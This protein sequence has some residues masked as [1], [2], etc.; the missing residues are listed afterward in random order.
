MAVTQNTYTGD[1]ST[2]LFSFTFPYLETTD[3]KVSLNGTVTTA[4]TLANATTIEFNTAPANGAAIRIYRETDDS[5]LLA[6]FYPGSAIRSQDLNDNFTQTLYVS[7]ETSRNVA[8]AVA[9]QIPDG[10]ITTSKLVDGVITNA[11]V[12]SLGSP[13]V[14]FTQAGTG[15]TQRTVESKLQDVVSVKDFG[16]VGDGVAD[17]TAAFTVALSSENVV[18]VPVGVYRITSSLSFQNTDIVGEGWGAI[19]EGDIVSAADPL[20]KAGRSVSISNISLRYKASR[21]SGSETQG[22]RVLIATYGGANNYSLQRGSEIRN[23]FF[24]L[25]GTGIYSPTNYPAFSVTLDTLEIDGFTFRGIDFNAPN[26]TGNVYRNIYIKSTSA[27]PNAGF[28]LDGEESECVIDQ[29]NVEHTQFALA[30]VV[31]R[32]VRGLAASTIHIEG[33]DLASTDKSYLLFENSSGSIEALSVFYTRMSYDNTSVV[34]LGSINY[35]DFGTQYDPDVLR[36]LRIGVLHLKG[37]AQP[38]AVLYPSYPA[39]RRGFSGS[40]ITGFYLFERPNSFTSRD[41]YVNVES[42][43]WNCPTADNATYSSYPVGANNNIAFINKGYRT[44]NINGPW[45]TAN[46]IMLGADTNNSHPLLFDRNAYSNSPSYTWWFDDNTGVCHPASGQVGITCANQHTFRFTN[47]KLYPFVG[48]IDLGEAANKWAN[49]YSSN[50]RPGDGSV[51]WTS[52]SGTPEGSVTAPVGSLYTD[53]SGG[54]G[55]TLYVK[56]S[57][58]GNT[59]WVAK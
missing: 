46:Q 19:I 7:Q 11:K 37:I 36:Y 8:Q 24:G 14:T 43:V 12:T 50:F 51:I 33:C 38:D 15:A 44:K 29:L 21:I 56:Q 57:G 53:R 26:R 35:D 23:I 20:I 10:T 39:A 45:F 54:A 27:T 22:Q 5:D 28:Y 3:V 13:K 40:T 2:V 52:G 55:T 1:G 59:G 30:P 31:L 49:V 41:F 42:Y 25:C 4:Y 48:N 18:H 9:G 58:T 16:A 17:D 47:Q 6:T 32:D 34:R